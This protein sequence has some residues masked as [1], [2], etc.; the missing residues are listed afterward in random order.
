M[1]RLSEEE[2]KARPDEFFFNS[3]TGR[4]NKTSK[5]KRSRPGKIPI[6]IVPPTFEYE[7]ETDE[8]RPK[9]PKPK[10]LTKG[11]IPPDVKAKQNEKTCVVCLDNK[12]VMV[13]T[14][15]GHVCYCHSCTLAPGLTK[16]CPECRTVSDTMIR[17]FM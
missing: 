11:K 2:K 17:I 8:D 5:A 10:N 16:K 9:P 7:D 14:G 4:Y 1:P 6:R 12:A 15:C 3:K 13:L